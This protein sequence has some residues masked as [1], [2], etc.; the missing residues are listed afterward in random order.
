M[1]L[2]VTTEVTTTRNNFM[3][4]VL[5]AMLGAGFGPAPLY[6][7]GILSP[8]LPPERKAQQ[9]QSATDRCIKAHLHPSPS[10]HEGYHIP[11]LYADSK[12]FLAWRFVA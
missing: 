8:A 4:R 5:S 3:Q 12:I 9:G 10:Y 11:D 1:S 6:R 7:E 2:K